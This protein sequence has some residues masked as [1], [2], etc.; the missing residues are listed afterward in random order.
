M[1]EGGGLEIRRARKGSRGSNPFSSAGST[2]LEG[3]LSMSRVNLAEAVSGRGC[4]RCDRW[5]TAERFVETGGIVWFWRCA[6]GWSSALAESGTVLRQRVRE[7][8]G[9]L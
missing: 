9:A 8:L 6:C 1:V 5:V 4:P 3:G 2:I 7:A